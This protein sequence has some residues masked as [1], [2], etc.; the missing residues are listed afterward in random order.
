ME[1]S[2]FKSI[3]LWVQ[4]LASN[5]YAM[6]A[7]LIASILGYFFPIKDI[8][9][10]LV[11]FFILDV[12]FGYLAARKLRKERFSVKI[13]WNHTMPRM[14]ISIVLILGAYMWDKTFQQN[15]VCTY[16]VIG[17][18]IS[19]VLLYS[20]AENGYH[21]TKWSVFP[22]IGNLFKD[23][24]KESTGLDINDKKENDEN[25]RTKS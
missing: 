15:I 20:I 1:Y 14:M 25:I 13:I 18:F 23:K 4:E 17:W 10:L 8:A 21:I 11:L 6:F 19:G 7:G 5:V 22:N 24:I 16:K 3:A 12:I 9:H 2:F